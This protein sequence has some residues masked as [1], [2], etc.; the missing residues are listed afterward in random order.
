M[1]YNKNIEELNKIYDDNI[2]IQ[3]NIIDLIKLYENNNIKLSDHDLFIFKELKNRFKLDYHL[4]L[5]LLKVNIM[6]YSLYIK[7]LDKN[8]DVIKKEINKSL[9]K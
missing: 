2:N 7:S 3:K 8:I 5:A 4:A 6:N 9:K 1:S